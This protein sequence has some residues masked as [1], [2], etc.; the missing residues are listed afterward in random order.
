VPPR[1]L[2]TGI[3]GQDG[4]YLAELLVG[5]DYEVWGTVHGSPDDEHPNLESMRDR[6]HLLAC[7]LLDPTAIAAALDAC[8]P[9]EVYNLASIS[10][11]PR[12]WEEPLETIAVNAAAVTAM[13]EAVRTSHPQARVFSAASGEIYGDAPESPQ[14]E[15]T[16]C[17]PRTP[18]AIA[19]LHAH[20]TVGAYR[21]QHGLHASSGIAFNHES[22]RRPAAFVTRKVT[23]AAAAIELGL[24][25]ELVLGDLDAVRDWGYAPDFV[26]A[27][28][29]MLQQD[30]PDDYVIATGVGHTV[31]ELVQ[32][33]FA[34]AGVD[35]EAHV[36]VDPDLVRAREETASVGDARPA[37]ARLGWAPRTSFADMIAEMVEADRRALAPA[38]ERT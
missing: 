19:K 29:L 7:D 5:R 28:W 1:A 32:R 16:P 9:D 27:M 12:S 4:S 24:E 2:I 15:D 38:G 10:F 36:R 8:R 25:D 22:P 17:R 18:Y 23:R 31:G 3:T 11:V 13:L 21:A 26:E 30:Q 20:L 34:S 35:P 33:A 6:V 37:H 14:D